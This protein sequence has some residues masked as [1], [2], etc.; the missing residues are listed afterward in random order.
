MRIRQ[1]SSKVIDLKYKAIGGNKT[2]LGQVVLLVTHAQWSTLTTWLYTGSLGP[3][4][5]TLAH[6]TGSRDYT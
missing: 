2:A 3:M 6:L 4:R 5:I 1:L